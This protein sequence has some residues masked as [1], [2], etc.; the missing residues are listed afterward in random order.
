MTAWAVDYQT[1][2][3]V[4]Q[5]GWQYAI[6]FP[7]SYHGRKGFTDYVRRRRWVRKAHLLTSGPWEELASTK[8]LH[9]SLRN[10][11]GAGSD[12]CVHAWAVTVEGEAVFRRGVTANCPAVSPQT[13][14]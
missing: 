7:A 6:D 5:D 14:K 9:V 11:D 8:L 3:G 13:K 1:P 10:P 2:G 4:D 12:G